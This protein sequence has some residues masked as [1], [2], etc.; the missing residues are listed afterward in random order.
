MHIAVIGPGYVGLPTAAVFAELGNTVFLVGRD[1]K[2]NEQLKRGEVY[3]HEKGLPELIAKHV[4]SGRIIPTLS[5]AEAIPDADVIFI[6]VGTPSGMHGEAD[7]TQVFEVATEIAQHLITPSSPLYKVIVIKSTV[8]VGTAERVKKIIEDVRCQM[9]NVKCQFDVASCPEFLR[10]GTAVE[11]ALHPDRI[12]IGVMSEKARDILL[13]LHAPLPG[14]RVV[15]DPKSAELIKYAS[16]AFLATKISFINEVANIC[17]SVGAD[18]EEVSR[19]MGLDS[20]IGA[21]FLKAGAGWSGS[22]FPKDVRALHHI[23]F[24]NNYEPQI[25]KAAIEVNNDQRRRLVVKLEKELGDLRGKKIVLLGLAFKPHTDDIR[26]SAAIDLLYLLKSAG[27]HVR[28]HDPVARPDER[29]V[30]MDVEFFE[31]P[32]SAFIGADAC[33]IA[34]EWPQFREFDWARI[35]SVMRQPILVDGR[36]LLDPKAMRAT[37]WTYVSVGRP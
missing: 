17:E 28:I 21:K 1:A 14:A 4:K 6:A 18:V 3:L 19:G 35:K 5:Y 22:C 2:R 26:E 31:E 13:E 34:T 7:L 11:D 27:L 33:V 29:T 23:A 32:Y 30:F 15:T 12:V 24:S 20:R 9:S 25:L 37:G 8:P 16:N 10:E 36:N